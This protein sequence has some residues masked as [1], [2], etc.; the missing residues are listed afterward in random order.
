VVK[1]DPVRK[2]L[3]FAEVKQRYMSL[4]DDGEHWQS[5]KLN[6][7][8]TSIRDLVVKDDD[9]VIGTMEE[10]SGYWM[11]LHRFANLRVN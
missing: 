11:I 10:V 8:A 2:G 5:L 3:L 9:L 1:E 4:L 6:M 7:P